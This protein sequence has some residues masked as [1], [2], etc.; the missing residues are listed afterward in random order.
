MIF[1][2]YFQHDLLKTILFPIE[3]PWYVSYNQLI[4]NVEWICRLSVCS[5]DLYIYLYASFYC[6]KDFSFTGSFEIEKLKSSNFIHFFKNRLAIP[7]ALHFHIH[8]RISLSTAT[9]VCWY[10]DSNYIESM[11]QL[12]EIS[13]CN[14]IESSYPWTWIVSPFI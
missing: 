12:D 13:H 5:I 7:D 6:L 4:V 1:L 2:R 8:F 10:F 9:K 11:D 14:N 3:L